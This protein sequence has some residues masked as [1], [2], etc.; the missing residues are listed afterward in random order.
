MSAWRSIVGAGLS[1]DRGWDWFGWR[2]KR[3]K[4]RGARASRSSVVRYSSTGGA[5]R[6]KTV[7]KRKDYGPKRLGLVLCV[8]N[9]AS[10]ALEIAWQQKQRPRVRMADA[11]GWR[12]AVSRCPVHG[13]WAVPHNRPPCALEPSV[14]RGLDVHRRVRQFR[15]ER[16]V[17]ALRRP[18][19]GTAQH[20]REQPVFDKDGVEQVEPEVA[21]VFMSWKLVSVGRWRCVQPRGP[22]VHESGTRGAHICGGAHARVAN[23]QV[24]PGGDV[25]GGADQL[26]VRIK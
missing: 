23:A 13:R 10:Y 17:A 6:G 2:L 4:G 14:A 19:A 8:S 3:N 24:G 5:A 22:Y 16:D 9:L 15:Y 26:R 11:A 21:W 1:Y 7:S 18:R 25:C 12:V 20:V